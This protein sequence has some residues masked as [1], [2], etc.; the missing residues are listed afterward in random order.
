MAAPSEQLAD[1]EKFSGFGV[2]VLMAGIIVESALFG[3][4]PTLLFSPALTHHPRKMT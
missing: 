1:L 2:T 3:L 4:S